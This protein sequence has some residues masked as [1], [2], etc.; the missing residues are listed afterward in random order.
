MV[1]RRGL[2]P[3]GRAGLARAE[4]P[5]ASTAARAAATCTRRCSP[6]SSARCGS[7]GLAAGIGAHID[8]ATPPI[9]KFGTDDQK[10]RY[11]APAIRGEKIARARRS[12]SPT[13]APTWRASGRFARRV[14]GG[15]VVNG[16][17]MFI[18]NGVRADFCVTAV[19]DDRARA[20]TT[21]SSFLIVEHEMDGRRAPRQD[22]EA[23]LARVRHRASSPSTTCSCPRRTCSASENEGFYLIMANFQWERLLMALGAVGAMQRGARED[24]GLRRASAARSASR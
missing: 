13:P 1:S 24:G 9:W 15:C 7:G 23:R 19:E 8:I 6:R 21:G 12:P 3:H 2:P 11:L 10:E 22:R 16:S 14:D 4:V 18:T 5:G 20:A 17:K